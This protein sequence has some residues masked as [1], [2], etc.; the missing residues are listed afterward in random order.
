MDLVW[1]AVVSDSHLEKYSALKRTFGASA[2]R[3][4]EVFLP[5]EDCDGSRRIVRDTNVFLMIVWSC[6]QV[7]PLFELE[8]Y[9]IE[10]KRERYSN[11]RRLVSIFQLLL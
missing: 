5:F 1:C 8:F 7:M 2:W 10:E 9:L 3:L 4:K 6:A 11:A